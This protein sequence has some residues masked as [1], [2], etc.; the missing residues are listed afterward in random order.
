MTGVAAV[1]RAY[2]T[3]GRRAWIALGDSWAAGT[4]D[5]PAEGGWV[6]RAASRLIGLERIDQFHNLAVGSA[7]AEDV[8][9]YQMS[10]VAFAGKAKAT[11]ISVIVGANDVT[12]SRWAG[13]LA[14]GLFGQIDEL[15]GWALA[16]GEIVFTATWPDHFPGVSVRK[17]ESRRRC[18]RAVNDH[19]FERWCEA[20]AWPALRPISDRLRIVEVDRILGDPALWADDRHINTEGHRRLAD[21]ATALLEA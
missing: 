9:N 3:A 8:I 18:A 21:A 17:H 13:G 6:Q 12:S 16:N 19:L 15:L 11:I 4:G 7:Y 5:D 2:V 10:R 1:R 20:E 14:S